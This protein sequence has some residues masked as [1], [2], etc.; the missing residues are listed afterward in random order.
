M[1]PGDR[2]TGRYGSAVHGSTGVRPSAGMVDVELDDQV[3]TE[4]PE[5]GPPTEPS[6]ADGDGGDRTGLDGHDRG[7]ARARRTV[8][9]LGVIAIVLAVVVT[10]NVVEARRVDRKVAA[11]AA[12]PGL[13]GSLDEPLEQ[14]WELD[15]NR[16]T[17]VA[18]DLLI[19][20]EAGTYRATDVVT[21]EQRWQVS[22]AAAARADRCGG[23]VGTDTPMVLCWRG[24]VGAADGDTGAGGA[25]PAAM[26]GLSLQDGSVVLER[27]T[28]L[29]SA[30][31]GIVDGDLVTGD[32]TGRVLAVQ[33]ID[34]STGD[35]RW[36]TEV[37]LVGRQVS[38]GYIATVRASDG[39]VLVAGPT[40]AVLS[41]DDGAVLGI[42]HHTD[43][44][45]LADE[46]NAVTVGTTT[47]GFAV[48]E[49]MV[50]GQRSGV[51]TWYPTHGE[52]VPIDGF[53]A[54]PAMSDGSAP[55][56]LLLQDAT[57][58]VLEAIDATTGEQLWSVELPGGTVLMRRD[59]ALVL[60]DAEQVLA[61]DLRKGTELWS[62]PVPG[63]RADGRFVSDGW[64]L[65]VMAVQEGSWQMQAVWLD[66][67]ER[68]WHAI[69][70]SP[71]QLFV[72]PS[73][74][75]PTALYAVDGSVVV[76]VGQSLIGMA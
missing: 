47:R 20:Q 42:W 19:L 24:E 3:P 39:F 10:T 76:D 23:L 57:S 63:L 8:R 64:T 11:I 41:G 35:V 70:P 66:D 61:L 48:W 31:Y 9:W 13:V 7:P 27:E 67:G 36:A 26:I 55:G 22:R 16:V 58:S 43:P 54:E 49:Q 34:P 50:D 73:A 74:A 69:A 62:R 37:E 1:R 4:V 28:E 45:S 6:S 72:L 46:G 17:G 38:G 5:D 18:G 33:R 51:G 2:G 25:S 68:R 75:A 59:G 30:G 56:V 44:A 12:M 60:C 52:P 71:L 29:P 15:R 65:V 40:S 21:G 53:L 32:R 14:V